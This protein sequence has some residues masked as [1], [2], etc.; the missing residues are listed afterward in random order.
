M[1]NRNDDEFLR[2]LRD[3]ESEENSEIEKIEEFHN[4][5][6]ENEEKIES[7][8]DKYEDD[9]KFE[10]EKFAD[11]PTNNSKEDSHSEYSD[12]RNYNNINRIYVDKDYVDE[13]IAKNKSRFSALK[14]LALILTGA[15]LGSFL[16]PILQSKFIGP[17]TTR[18]NI[19]SQETINI[20]SS[21]EPNIENA[22]A[23]KAIPSVVGIHTSFI[24]SNP[25]MFGMEKK[26]EGIGSGVIVSEDGYILTNAHVIGNNPEKIS[27]LFSDNTSAEAEIVYKNTNLDLAVI[28]VNKTGLPAIEFADSSKVQIGDKAIAIGNPLGFNLQSTLTS[29]YISGLD[30]S[31]TMQDGTTM[32]SLMQTDASI[33]SGNSGG[34]LL[35]SNGQLI[36]INTAKAGST[37]G[38]GFAIPSNTSKN[39]VDQIIEKGSFSQVVLGINGIDLDLY[40]QYTKNRSIEASKGVYIAEVLKNSS[41]E[42][43]GLK[44][45]DVITHIDDMEVDSMNKLQQTLITKRVGEN[46]KIKIIRDNKELTLDII[47]EGQQANI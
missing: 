44:A 43:A 37:D 25:F 33:N 5:T 11:N 23:K 27:V 3:N 35:N 26:A 2:W 34:A 47:Y 20:N 1:T 42:K 30:R 6:I 4:D 46:G 31:I 14:I 45:G 36:G 9:L 40:K 16:G 10:D 22:V 38:I 15:I 17:N 7:D 32:T 12:K 19:T 39:I 18:S 21:D 13:Q 28:K 24:Q 8:E 41:A 29:G